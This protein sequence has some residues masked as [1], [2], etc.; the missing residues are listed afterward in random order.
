MPRRN[1][2]TDLLLFYLDQAFG[3]RGWHGP[4]LSAALRGVRPDEAAWKPQPK[5]NSIWQ[6]V[7]HAA[8]WKSTVRQRLDPQRAE[9]PFPRSPANFPAIPETPTPRD[10]ARD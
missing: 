9:G 5:R 2:E 6:L 10:W 3:R 7:L 4:T 8:F 1:P